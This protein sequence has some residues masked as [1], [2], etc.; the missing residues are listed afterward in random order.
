MAPDRHIHQR[1]RASPE[2]HGREVRARGRE[3]ADHLARALLADRLDRIGALARAAPEDQD[4]RS[5][6]RSGRIVKRLGE[7]A[8]RRQAACRAVE[9]EHPARGLISCIQ[10]PE[11]EES[12]AVGHD[13][14]AGQRG[15][16]RNPRPRRD[17]PRP[18]S[19]GDCARGGGVRAIARAVRPPGGD[20]R[21]RRQGDGRQSYESA[22]ANRGPA[23]TARIVSL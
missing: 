18:R 20:R 5:K 11:Y 1:R 14:L 9:A 10:T 8:G 4:P 22:P 21:R 3:P 23:R 2:R 7:S 13:G 12:T 15:G 6:Y 19:V 17:D 16:E